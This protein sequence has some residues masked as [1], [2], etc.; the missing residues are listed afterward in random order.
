[1]RILLLRNIIK[2]RYQS[3]HVKIFL[4]HSI[5]LSSA[6]DEL[7]ESLQILQYEVYIFKSAQMELTNYLLWNKNP[8]ENAVKKM[9]RLISAGRIKISDLSVYDLTSGNENYHDIV[10]L[11]LVIFGDYRFYSDFVLLCAKDFGIDV[12]LLVTAQGRYFIEE[13]E[14]LKPY[15]ARKG[16][17]AIWDKTPYS[18]TE[19]I[20]KNSTVYLNGNSNHRIRLREKI[21]GNTG[22]GT[23]YSTSERGYLCKIYHKTV[24]QLGLKNKLEYIIRRTKYNNRA[25]WPLSVVTNSAGQMVGFMMKEINGI[26]MFDLMCN[27]DERQWLGTI[28]AV[29]Y[30]VSETIALFHSERILVGDISPKDIIFDRNIK[31]VTFIDTDSFQYDDYPCPGFLYEYKHKNLQLSDLKDCVRPY[32]FED[33]SLAVLLY[34]FMTKGHFPNE[35][36][37]N[38]YAMDFDDVSMDTCSVYDYEKMI[39]PFSINGYTEEAPESVKK[40]WKIIPVEIRKLFIEE[41]TYKRLVSASEWQMTFAI[42]IKKHTTN[43]NN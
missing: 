7:I 18:Y 37:R 9:H 39:F 27:A 22:E 36:K 20:R 33:F 2:N 3:E 8:C 38:N 32:F 24:L 26:S 17:V 12:M 4:H 19:T 35:R 10:G 6:F 1:M 41:F 42:L 14:K 16:F 11:Y 21:S 23:V 34:Q 30:L 43:I 15:V 29:G 13:S 31:T 25:A 5:V 28:L 40:Y